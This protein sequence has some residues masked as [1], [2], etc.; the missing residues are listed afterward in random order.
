MADYQEEVGARLRRLR[1]TRNWTQAEAAQAV[2]VGSKTWHLWETGKTHP[3][4][5]NWRR[6]GEVLGVDPAEI[7]GMS[8]PNFALGGQNM[9]QMDRIESLLTDVLS[10]LGGLDALA[11]RLEALE[12]QARRTRMDLEL[13]LAAERRR[14]EEA[15]RA[16]R[17]RPQQGP[18]S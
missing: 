11:D 2:G 14:S 16:R 5:R 13:L 12:E 1:E 3:Y 7:R 9:S 6:L 18:P 10:R 15:D 17:D 4:E 8:T